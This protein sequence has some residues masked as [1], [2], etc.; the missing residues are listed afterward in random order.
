M[1]IDAPPAKTPRD[2]T[3]PPESKGLS[4][5][6]AREFYYFYTGKASDI[7][8]QLCFAG[9]AVVWIFSGASVAGVVHVKADL[10]RVAL[11]LIIALTLDCLQYVYGAV[12]W[13]V[14]S[15]HQ[16]TKQNK[17]GKEATFVAPAWINRP[18]MTLFGLKLLSTTVAYV[19]LGIALG[20]RLVAA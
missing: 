2:G 13:G 15:R 9:I 7:G 1:T 16:E 20:D 12:A 19:L 5:S 3:S 14:F 6:D 8:R 11:C 17:Q 18:T 4:L 10:L